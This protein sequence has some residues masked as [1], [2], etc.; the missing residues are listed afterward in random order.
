MSQNLRSDAPR[1]W[2]GRRVAAAGD[3]LSK[4][5]WSHELGALPTFRKLFYKVARVLYLAV[6]G[7]DEDRCLLRAGAL[8]FMTGLSI[9][10]LLAFAFS[11][12]KG[13]G[14][15]QQ[16]LDVINPFLDEVLGSAAAAGT[17]QSQVEVRAAVDQVLEYV[18]GTELASLGTFGL[19]ILVYTVIKLLGAIEASLN[20]IWGVK[21][22]R[23]LVRKV[24]DYL[25]IIVI[26]P[27]LLATATAVTTAINSS[28]VMQF[29]QDKL[30]GGSSE[31]VG[32]VP[33]ATARETMA[34]LIRSA[35]LFVTW[36]GFT[37]VYLFLPNTRVKIRSAILGGIVGGTMWQLAQ[38]LHVR[39]QVGVANYNAIYSTFAALPIFMFWLYLS[40]ITVL[41]GAEF[42]NAHQSEPAYR[43]IAR[44]RSH[45]HPFLEVLALRVMAR[46]AVV[47][48]RGEPPL[49]ASRLVHELSV[50]DRSLEDVLERLERAGLVTQAEDEARR[51]AHVLPSRDLARIRVQDVLDALNGRRGPS[52][53]PTET[54]EDRVLAAVFAEFEAEKRTSARNLTFE[55]IA[56]R[57]LEPDAVAEKAVLAAEGAVP[58][59]RIE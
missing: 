42:A 20:D 54:P 7:F 13:L 16:L 2:F 35:T 58:V 21:K 10:P 6:R 18:K 24:A 38:V 17:S 41:L 28:D 57:A 51:D 36:I 12:A 56:R 23:T 29:L 25:S 5:V 27:V 33:E 39:F 22:S 55:A 44:A 50:P 45:D 52:S 59:E 1:G 48:L 46:I 49:Y 31:A 19:G 37:F 30:G 4:D 40:W 3:F 34:R 14:A 32:L 15:Y 43:Q 47:F 8:T 53:I 11:V 26:V 9:V